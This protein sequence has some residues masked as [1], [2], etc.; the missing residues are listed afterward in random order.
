MC[1]LLGMNCAAPTDFCFSLKGFVKRGGDT[2]IHSHGWGMCVYEGKKGAI[3]CFHDTLPAC[4]SPIAEL[5]Q[6]YPMRSYN[7]LA[8]IRYAT[9]G[10]VSL[11][12]VH[13]FSRVWKGVQMT[14]CHN[15]DCPHFGTSGTTQQQLHSNGGD[16]E[17]TAVNLPLLG[18]TTPSDVIY[19]PVGDTDSEAVFCA[20]LNALHVEFPNGLPTLPVLHEFLSVL[21][22]EIIAQHPE[23]T[24]FNF[25]LGCGQH[26]LFAYS[27]PGKRPTSN[28]WN[29]LYYIVR[30]PPFSTAKLLDT[31]YEIDFRRVT[32]PNDR[33][34]VITTKPLTEEAGWTEFRRNE[35][36]MFNRGIPYRTPKCC[37][38]AEEEGRGLS[39]KLVKSKCSSR[40]SPRWN[41][42]NSNVSSPPR[43][44]SDPLH[45][46]N[47]D[48][49]CTS[50]SQDD[51][52]T[53][54]TQKFSLDDDGYESPEIIQQPISLDEH[55]PTSTIISMHSER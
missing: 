48:S 55:S 40:L 39:S 31:D 25:L 36:I 41:G 43:L 8:H 3:R 28:V 51:A 18:Q 11:E 13:P 47:N 37:Q 9:Q 50:K 54:L 30:E 29:G 22:N 38:I 52:S 12:N 16:D 1:Q 35:L 46:D 23:S 34:A 42:C 6:K 10:E 7:M 5:V 26:T 24:I 14:F 21:C 49:A 53:L 2:D 20:I 15:G 33:V 45:A 19:H 44:I 27:W 4:I 32:T 17:G